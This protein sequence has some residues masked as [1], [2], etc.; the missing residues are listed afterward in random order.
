MKPETT[1][2]YRALE[3]FDYDTLERWLKLHEGKA[4]WVGEKLDGKRTIIHKDGDKVKIYSDEKIEFTH[5]VPHVVEDVKK[6]NVKSVILDGETINHRNGAR[7]RREETVKVVNPRVKTPPQDENI[8]V[9]VFDCLYFNGKDLSKEP[10]DIRKKYLHKLKDLPHVKVLREIRAIG[11]ENILKIV[12]KIVKKG[13]NKATRNEGAMLKLADSRYVFGGAMSWAKFKRVKTFSGIV[14]E[15]N[16]V[17]GAE[18]WNYRIGVQAPKYKVKNKI[19]TLKGKKYMEICKTYNTKKDVSIGT[20]VEVAVTRIL[21]KIKKDGTVVWSASNPRIIEIREDRKEPNSIQVIENIAIASEEHKPTPE[22]MCLF[23]NDDICPWQ[24]HYPNLPVEFC[25]FNKNL[26]CKKET[27]NLKEWIQQNI[28]EPLEPIFIALED[29]EDEQEYQKPEVQLV[30]LK[31]YQRG[32]VQHHWRGLPPD[33]ARKYAGISEEEQEFMLSQP[34]DKWVQLNET[35]AKKYFDVELK[36]ERVAVKGVKIPPL[37]WLM[38]HSLHVD[39]RLWVPKHV[40][41]IGWTIVGNK[42]K[43]FKLGVPMIKYVSVTKA[44][45]PPEWLDVDNLFTFP[46]EVGA[47]SKK[48]AY[49]RKLDDFKYITGRIERKK[50]FV[51]YHIKDGKFM[52]GRWI[53]RGLRLPKLDKTGKPVKGEVLRILIFKPKD[54]GF[55]SEGESDVPVKSYS[56]VPK[57]SEQKP[58]NFDIKK[59][60]G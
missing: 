41:C 24:K 39:E 53:H 31:T 40:A 12:K 58:P 60:Y 36:R 13:E 49:F 23:E 43:L 18:A 7:L 22:A 48:A 26:S 11:T 35:C 5:R 15:K 14:L 28:E 1:R 16:K 33:E 56:I 59:L 45:Q 27:V 54:G 6:L 52:N 38:P 32:I 4:I 46:G 17:K 8:I 50:Y 19:W 29:G 55:P 37:K 21:K 42:D 20:I 10:L 30:P 9:Y 3:L 25:N 44:L 2:A 51:E 34:L 47:T 57:G